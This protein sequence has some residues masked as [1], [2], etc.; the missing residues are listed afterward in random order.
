M[1]KTLKKLVFLIIPIIMLVAIPVFGAKMNQ[2]KMKDNDH[3][4]LPE[5]IHPEDNKPSS[6]KVELG[7]KLFMDRRLSHNNTFSCAMCHVPEQGFAVNEIAT[8]IGIEGRT[9]RRNAS[10]ALNVGFQ[11]SFFHDGREFSLEDQVIGPLITHNEM[12]NPSVGYVVNKLSTLTDYDGMF[13]KAFEGNGV[14]IHRISQAIAVYERTLQSGNSKFD[15]W[16]YGKES[17]ALN[18]NEINGFKLFSGK[19]KCVTCHTFDKKS[20]LFTDQGFHNLGVGWERLNKVSDKNTITVTVAPGETYEVDADHINKSAE[21]IPNDVGRFEI[22]EDPKDRWLYRTPILRNVAITG[23]Y[24]HD[25]SLFTLEEVV[26][27]YNKGGE[28]NPLKDPL[29]NPLGLVEQE[30]KDLVSFLKALTGSNVERLAREARAAYVGNGEVDTYR[31]ERA[32]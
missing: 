5:M 24:M 8:A 9:N 3:L 27:F 20:A 32:R 4:G 25:G 10:T 28:D 14:S 16:Y 29:I 7:R 26:D 12:G 1:D 18:S 13:E 22:T 17:S 23:P 19:A 15:R 21:T 6:A 11:T 2:V 31:P 30:K